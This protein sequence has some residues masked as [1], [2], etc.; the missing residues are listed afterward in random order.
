MARKIKWSAHRSDKK[1]GTVEELDDHAA[2]RYVD[3]GMAVYVD[4]DAPQVTPG[5]DVAPQVTVGPVAAADPAEAT[6]K[7]EAE[8]TKP[9]RNPRV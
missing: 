2:E 6:A 5:P 7:L 8:A 1:I 9:P 4:D 3:T